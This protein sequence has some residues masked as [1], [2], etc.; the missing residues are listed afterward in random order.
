MLVDFSLGEGTVPEHDFIKIAMVGMDAGALVVAEN[1][2]F[3][4]AEVVK[5]SKLDGGAIRDLYA[6]DI[7]IKYEPVV[8]AGDMM[9]GIIPDLRSCMR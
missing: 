2:V 9:P 3:V 6:V 4:I 8:G 5:D 7:E 1:E